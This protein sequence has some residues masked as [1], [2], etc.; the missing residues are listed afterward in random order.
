MRFKV[1]A[2]TVVMLAAACL[3]RFIATHLVVAR[4][5]LWHA[6]LIGVCASTLV[7]LLNVMAPMAGLEFAILPSAVATSDSNAAPTDRES[8]AVPVVYQK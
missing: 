8:I 6:T 3:A 2:A 7:P 4:E 1:H 5:R